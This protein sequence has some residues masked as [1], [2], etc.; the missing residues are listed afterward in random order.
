MA[1]VLSGIFKSPVENAC[2]SFD[3]CYRKYANASLSSDEREK[4]RKAAGYWLGQVKKYRKI[5]GNDW[6]ANDPALKSRVDAVIA[7]EMKLVTPAPIQAKE[8]AKPANPFA[9]PK[10]VEKPPMEKPQETKLTEKKP[11][12]KKKTPKTEVKKVE[13]PAETKAAKIRRLEAQIGELKHL[14][15][16]YYISPVGMMRAE[17]KPDDKQLKDLAHASVNLKK[18]KY[19]RNE[20]REAI[21]KELQKAET[22]L[23]ALTPAEA[24]KERVITDARQLAGDAKYEYLMQK[25]RDKKAAELKQKPVKT[26]KKP[27]E[28]IY[29]GYAR[30]EHLMEEARK[31]K[32]KEES[33]K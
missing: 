21:G 13:A 6:L 12:G 24:K 17:F 11:A 33:A 22:G 26:E 32:A 25:A 4:A 8:E 3:D 18:G 19:S 29:S 9:V 5:G 23:R 27:E 2:N 7:K 14:D 15:N 28:K 30:Y 16:R 10:P 31:K 1:N 20:I